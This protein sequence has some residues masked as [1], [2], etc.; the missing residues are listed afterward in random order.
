MYIYVIKKNDDHWYEGIM[1]NEN[2][3]VVIGNNSKF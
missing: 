2:G 1:K 3:E